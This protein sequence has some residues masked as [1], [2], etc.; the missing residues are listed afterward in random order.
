MT[1]HARSI[2]PFVSPLGKLQT[3]YLVIDLP[4]VT[5]AYRRICQSMPDVTPFYA[6]KSNPDPRLAKH[7]VSLGGRFEIASATEMDVLRKI[8][9]DPGSLL[10]TNPV[11]IPAHVHRAHQ[12]GVWRF[13]FDSQAELHKIA[14]YAPGA[15]VMVRLK[16]PAYDS[17]VSSEGKFGV[18]GSVAADLMGLAANLGL[19]PYGIAFHVGSQMESPKPWETAIAEAAKLM[20]LLETRGIKVELLD[21]GG[22]FPASYETP[23]PPITEYGAAITAALARYLPYSV[24]LAAEPGRYLVANAGTLVSTIIGIAERNG[25]VWLHLDVGAFNGVMEALETRNTLRF[26]VSDSQSNLSTQLYNLTGPSCDSQDSILFGV[27]LSAGLTIGDQVFIHA[28]GAYSTCYASTFNGFTIPKTYVCANPEP[29]VP[30]EA[31]EAL[32]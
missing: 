28:T 31:W 32:R 22:G 30:R 7:I 11:K 20:R 10:F 15:A 23:V 4:T 14:E 27:P 9:V 8:G 17:V 1:D 21:I 5:T 13:S 18:N 29:T 16:A 19:K 12:A 26:P 6:I 25:K 24:A 2:P 3:P